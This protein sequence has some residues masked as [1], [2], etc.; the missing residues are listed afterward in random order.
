LYNLQQRPE[1]GDKYIML[2]SEQLVGTALFVLAKSALTDS[3]RNVEG[4]NRKTGLKGMSGNK[5]AVA[6]RLDLYDTS[7]CF[8]TAHLAAGQDNVLERNA[9]YRTIVDGLRFLRG[10]AIDSHDNIIWAADT[11]YRI[12]LDN[13][14]VRKYAL[15]SELDTLLARDQLKKA[16]DDG[17]VF[18]GYEE[19]AMLFCPTYRYDLYSENYDTSEKLRTPAWTDRILYR[20]PGLNC[21]KYDRAELKSSDHRPVFAL[22]TTKARCIDTIKRDALSRILFEESRQAASGDKLEEKLATVSLGSAS[23]PMPPPSSDE[24]AWWNTPRH[25]D[26]LVDLPEPEQSVNAPKNPW[27]SPNLSLPSPSSSDE[28]LYTHAIQIQSDG[29]KKPPPPPIPAKPT[30]LTTRNVNKKEESAP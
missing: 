25:P 27:D 5:G 24:A 19:G 9:D 23:A 22:L 6:I 13:D 18:H 17:D 26:G 10:K 11:N 1:I 29:P 28:E 3:I 16:M 15:A 7:F 8:I 20:G 2:R 21:L 4:A 12:D 14:S 30:Q